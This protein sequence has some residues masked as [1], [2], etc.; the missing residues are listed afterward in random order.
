MSTDGWELDDYITVPIF[1][2]INILSNTVGALQIREKRAIFTLIRSTP[3]AT[4]DLFFPH[5]GI[6]A[7]CFCTWQI[8]TPWP[9]AATSPETEPEPPASNG[10]RLPHHP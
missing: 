2:K 5:V 6:T 3:D 9:P 7:G 4:H 1:T 8:L 10:S